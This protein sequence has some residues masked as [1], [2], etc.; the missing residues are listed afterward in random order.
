MF[1]K[2]SYEFPDFFEFL[3]LVTSFIKIKRLPRVNLS[4]KL[5]IYFLITKQCKYLETYLGRP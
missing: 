5:K 4:I 1:F 2:F 3:N